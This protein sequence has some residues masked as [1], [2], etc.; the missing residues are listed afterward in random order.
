[1]AGQN[2]SDIIEAYLKQILA[3]EQQIE[4]NRS[5]V[6]AQF[7][8]VPSQINYVIKTRFTTQ[9][10]YLVESKRGGGGYIRIEKMQFCDQDH[11]LDRLIKA[12]GTQITL[13]RTLM[14]LQQLIE[15]ELLSEREARLLATMLTDEALQINDQ[16]VAET[17]RANM[18][19]ALV[20]GLRYR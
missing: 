7:N 13:S 1:M 16:R 3:A 18:L 2:I 10:G 6:A 9:Q 8:C 15:T 14:A 5:E 19:V 20:D 17:V 12:I 11:Y 4:I